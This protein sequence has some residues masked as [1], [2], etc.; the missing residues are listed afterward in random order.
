MMCSNEARVGGILVISGLLNNTNGESGRQ[1][2]SM[3]LI[4][5]LNLKEYIHSQELNAKA[6]V[7]LHDIWLFTRPSSPPQHDHGRLK[8]TPK[9][10]L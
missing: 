10:R 1:R 7:K 6:G 4:R 8:D 2:I 3:P 9:F 5:G